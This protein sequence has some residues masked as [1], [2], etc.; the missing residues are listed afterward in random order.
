VSFPQDP[1]S[2]TGQ[3]RRQQRSRRGLVVGGVALVI[4][5]A[6]IAVAVSAGSNDRTRPHLAAKPEPT[7]T[8]TTTPS[9]DAGPFTIAAS[10]VLALAVYP[11]PTTTGPPIVTLGTKSTYGL[12]T[13]VA[14]DQAQISPSPDWVPVVIPLRK[15][16]S[17]I[18]WVQASQVTLSQ[19]SY[20]VRVSLREHRLVLLDA[21]KEVMASTVIIGKPQTPTPVGRFY[22]TDS[23]NCNT[24]LV[25]AYPVVTCA[26]AYGVYALPLS[27][28]SE[29]LDSFQGTIPQLALHGTDLPDTEF[30]KDLS[31]GCV[32]LP[33]SVILRLGEIVPVGTPVEITA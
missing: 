5:V 3:S 16:N 20:L 24:Q 2:A 1:S 21:G 18:G 26:S 30:G 32:R 11:E 19:T 10:R 23:V 12:P 28:L 6:A 31:N 33:N 15:P 27:G 8:S 13:V 14:V 7:T 9:P 17:T 29:A 4:A 22:V 25:T